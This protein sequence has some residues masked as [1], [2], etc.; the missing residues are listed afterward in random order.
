MRHADQPARQVGPVNRVREEARK[1]RNDML[2]IVG[3]G[4]PPSRCSI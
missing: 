3:V 1:R 2:F 4:M